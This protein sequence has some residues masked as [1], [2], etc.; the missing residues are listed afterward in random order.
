VRQTDRQT[1]RHTERAG[2]GI[3]A[4]G[5]CVPV[6]GGVDNERLKVDVPVEQLEAALEQISLV[7]YRLI[8]KSTSRL[9]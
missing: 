6:G 4:A 3:P 8:Y 2:A 9:S 7:T 5:V 1:H